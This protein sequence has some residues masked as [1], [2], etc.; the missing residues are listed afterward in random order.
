[1]QSYT[2]RAVASRLSSHEVG[3]TETGG[4]GGGELLGSL[5]AIESPKLWCWR[6]G[7]TGLKFWVE[8]VGVGSLSFLAG[9]DGES[10][11]VSQVLVGG[12]AAELIIACR[13]WSLC[14]VFALC[15]VF[16]SS[17]SHTTSRK[18]GYLCVISGNRS[19]L[20]LVLCDLIFPL[21]PGI[22]GDSIFDTLAVGKSC[23]LFLCGI[24]NLTFASNNLLFIGS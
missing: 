23:S 6:D 11:S 2:L 9:L 19:G 12:T 15:W 7:G 22:L 8:L 20:L 4:Q 3:G 13:S 1:M 5:D 10:G 14:S 21:V 16:A 17:I 18:C 24:G